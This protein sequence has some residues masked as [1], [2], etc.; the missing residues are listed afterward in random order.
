VSAVDEVLLR[1]SEEKKQQRLLDLLLPIDRGSERS[2]KE[3][4]KILLARDLRRGIHKKVC[5]FD[6]REKTKIKQKTQS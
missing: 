4:H 6:A 5:K 1:A 2:R 3:G